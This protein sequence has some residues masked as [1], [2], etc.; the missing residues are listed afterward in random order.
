M[1]APT[2]PANHPPDFTHLDSYLDSL[3]AAA[4]PDVLPPSGVQQDKQP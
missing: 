4:T 2:T 1:A 3:A